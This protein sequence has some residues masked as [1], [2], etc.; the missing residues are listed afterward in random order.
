MTSDP[1]V[2]REKL[3]RETR[4]VE[5]AGFLTTKKKNKNKNKQTNK[6]NL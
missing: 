3:G 2:S 6:N 1:R 4:E 5:L